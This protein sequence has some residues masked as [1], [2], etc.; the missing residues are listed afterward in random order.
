MER[1]PRPPKM[2]AIVLKTSSFAFDRASLARKARNVL[3]DV[4]ERIE[5][6]AT[7]TVTIG[8]HTDAKGSQAYN[9]TL[10]VRRADSV[11]R[12]LRGLTATKVDFDVK[13]FGETRPVA[14][15]ATETGEDNPRG[16]ALNRRVEIVYAK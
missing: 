9:R 10:S 14:P 7:G 15:N 11:L 3:T 4:A 1:Y 8:G 5:R 6:E 2:T 12:E 16:R 13:G